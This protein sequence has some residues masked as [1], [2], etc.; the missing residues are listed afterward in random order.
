[1]SDDPAVGARSVIC[2]HFQL[3]GRIGIGRFSVVFGR[4]CLPGNSISGASGY[5][6]QATLGG[7]NHAIGCEHTTMGF[8]R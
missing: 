7:E 6:L 4:L 1:M 8:L 3:F 2:A 5:K